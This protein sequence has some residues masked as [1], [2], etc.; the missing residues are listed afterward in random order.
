MQLHPF[1]KLGGGRL[2]C[3]SLPLSHSDGRVL[4]YPAPMYLLDHDMAAVPQIELTT[5]D[6]VTITLSD[7]YLQDLLRGRD[8]GLVIYGSPETDFVSRLVERYVREA[9]DLP[10]HQLSEWVTQVVAE[11]RRAA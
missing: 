9:R 4:S 7:W 10:Q 1:H 8:T 6:Q 3:N 2:A 11:R 5:D